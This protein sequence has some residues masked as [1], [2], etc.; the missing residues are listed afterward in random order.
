MT[1]AARS[2]AVS[3]ENATAAATSV[4]SRQ[5]VHCLL[6]TFD[7]L[8]DFRGVHFSARLKMGNK[9]NLVRGKSRK[10]HFRVLRK[11]KSVVAESVKTLVGKGKPA[12]QDPNLEA[13]LLRDESSDF[14]EESFVSMINASGGALV[15]TP[16]KSLN[17]QF[18]PDGTAGS[19]SPSP[20]KA[21]QG[22]KGIEPIQNQAVVSKFCM[23]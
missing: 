2:S 15:S 20:L 19:G 10:R 11:L 12:E 14:D 6:W 22:A 7:T 1:H 16:K 21:Q 17:F 18:N 5:Q 23:L 9:K 4:T 8:S 13:L 3:A